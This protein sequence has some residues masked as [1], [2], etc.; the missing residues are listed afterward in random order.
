MTEPR[1]K[2]LATRL[3]RAG[4]RRDDTWRSVSMPIHQTAIFEHQRPL[5][6]GQDAYNYTRMGN[7]TRTALEEAVADLEGG[8]AALAF[9]SGMAAIAATLQLFQPGEHVIATEGLYGHTFSLMA[10]ILQPA[11]V[12]ITFVDTSEIAAVEAAW[13]ERTAGLF[14]EMPTNPLLRG[15]DIRAAARLCRERKARL[16]VDSTFLTPVGLRPLELGADIVV[17][18]A[19][20]YLAGHNDTLA[21]VVVAKSAALAEDL[22]YIRTLTGAVLAPFDAWLTLRGLKTLALRMERCQSNA[23]EIARWLQGHPLVTEVHYPG[24]K[25]HPSHALF[26]EQASG[27]GGVVSFAVRDRE[28]AARVLNATE[29]ILLAES[30]GGTETLIT[31]PWSQTHGNVPPEERTRLGIHDRLLRLSVG[32]ESVEDLIEDLDRALSA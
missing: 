8:A 19:T 16:I 24:L 4:V 7:P 20:K 18:S 25:E 26:R 3:A 14:V 2:G 10:N 21:G 1:R 11:G 15:T 22:Q 32:I 13:T 30:L 23:L 5:T 6:Q 29:L 9:S 17:H 31:Y 28:T 12:R 27:F